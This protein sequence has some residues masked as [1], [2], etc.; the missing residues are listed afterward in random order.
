MHLYVAFVI[1]LDNKKSPVRVGLG[2]LGAVNVGSV[3]VG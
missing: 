3:Q 1:K 2:T